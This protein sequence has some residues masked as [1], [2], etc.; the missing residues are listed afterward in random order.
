MGSF[1]FR[2]SVKLAP[3]LRLNFNKNSM[4]LTL[5]P[6]GAHYT[7]NTSGRVTTSV[8][9]PGT[10]LWYQDSYNKNTVAKTSTRRA[11]RNSN[12]ETES[13]EDIESADLPEPHFDQPGILAK[14]PERA[15]WQFL[16]DFFSNEN[17]ADK[18]KSLEETQAAA[19]KLRQNFPELSIIIDYLMISPTAGTSAEAA[20]KLCEKCWAAGDQL[21]QH[22]LTKKYFDQISAAIPIAPGIHFKTDY[23]HNYLAYSYS[24]LLQALGQPDKALE[25]IKKTPDTPLKELATLDLFLSAKRFVDVIQL[26]NE[27]TNDDD[28]TALKLIFRAVAFRDSGKPDIAIEIFKLALSK[29]Q[30]TQDILNYGLYERACTYVQLKKKDAAIKDL[31][32]VLAT[33]Y[34]NEAAKVKL[35]EL[36]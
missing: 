28:A 7:V 35:S 15:L 1:R 25:I 22:P 26:T 32:K 19:E 11:S 24:E 3:G 36:E 17:P 31:N 18:K 16:T 27:V 33:D 29:K 20:L 12:R 34:S 30:R 2:R 23:N 13:A 14:S 5:G 9:L 21:L 6:R 8:G 4:G 10:G